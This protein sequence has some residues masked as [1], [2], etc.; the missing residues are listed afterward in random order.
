MA[1]SSL[2]GKWFIFGRPKAP[3]A[4]RLFCFPYAGGAASVFAD[5]SNDLPDNVQVCGVQ[6][7]GRQNR[8]SETPY[9]DLSV[10]VE[11]LSEAF[12][13]YCDLPFALFGHS[14]GALISFEFARDLRR[15][16]LPL[17]VHLFVAGYAAPQLPRRQL[18]LHNVSDRELI[19]AL[20]RFRGTP[21]HLL[22]NEQ[23]M[24]MMLPVL[25]ADFSLCETYVYRPEEPLACPITALSGLSST[26]ASRTEL[27][28]WATQTTAD[29]KIKMFSGDHF[30]LT[31]ARTPLL[32]L[33]SE[34]LQRRTRNI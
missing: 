12:E 8:L 18:P 2:A 1:S 27:Q 6:L 22:Q 19:I 24:Q 11:D 7:P 4:M 15:K 34:E 23:L 14:M 20:H 10:L 9:R 30:F 13:D 31:T 28:Q 25:R 33:I 26:D 3:V 16:N 32:Q 5:W 21:E 29:F 17:P